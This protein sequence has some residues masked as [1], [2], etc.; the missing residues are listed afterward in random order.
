[1]KY[2]S[3]DIETTG[4]DPDTH[5]I[6]EIGIV[7]TD[8]NTREYEKHRIVILHKVITGSL[9]ALAMNAKLIQEI[10]NQ[11]GKSRS[12]SQDLNEM[13]NVHYVYPTDQVH[14]ILVGI[15]KNKTTVA[16]KNFNAFDRLFLSKYGVDHLFHRRALDPAELYALPSDL[17][18]PDLQTCLDRAGIEK[19]VSHTAVED[20]M[21]VI[22]LLELKSNIYPR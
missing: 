3:I 9:P 10:N 19:S 13:D 11:G 6:L 18:L 1:M 12:Y 5:Q 14:S 22:K 4:L 21:D 20:A 2:A 15:I 16:G 7:L 17:V 8:T